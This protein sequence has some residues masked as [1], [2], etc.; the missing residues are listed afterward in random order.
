MTAAVLLVFALISVGAARNGDFLL[1]GVVLGGFLAP[2]PGRHVLVDHLHITRKGLR[3][4]WVVI[5]G[6]SLYL[7]ASKMPLP[8]WAPPAIFAV[9]A[10]YLGAF[11]WLFS[12]WRIVRDR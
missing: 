4:A 7:Q 8:S 2:Y 3:L 12:D 10:T 5:V 9:V 1:L 11:F 6:G